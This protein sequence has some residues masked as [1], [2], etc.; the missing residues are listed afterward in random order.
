LCVLYVYLSFC[1]MIVNLHNFGGIKDNQSINQSCNCITYYI[2]L[3]IIF[4]ADLDLKYNMCI[5]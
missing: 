3:S 1:T 5:N 2:A 4:S